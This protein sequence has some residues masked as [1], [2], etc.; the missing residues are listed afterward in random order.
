MVEFVFF[1]EAECSTCSIDAG[2]T[3]MSFGEYGSFDDPLMFD[4]NCSATTLEVDAMEGWNYV[5]TNV[6]PED[7]AISTLFDAALGGLLKVLGDDDFALG[8]SYT[9]GIPGVFNSLQMRA[10]AAGYVKLNAD[11]LWS[12]TGEPLDPTHRPPST[13]MKAGTSSDMCP[14]WPWP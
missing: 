2:L 5:S 10:D 9:P 8:G 6:V 12:S 3:A 13:S 1:N 14:K 7:Y 11:A 4:A